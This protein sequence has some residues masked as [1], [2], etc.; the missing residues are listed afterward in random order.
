MGLPVDWAVHL[1]LA[2]GILRVR[3]HPGFCVLCTLLCLVLLLDIIETH[4]GWFE[5]SQT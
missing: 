3:N 2:S 1:L 4:E 5:F